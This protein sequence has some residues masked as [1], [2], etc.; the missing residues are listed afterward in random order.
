MTI[1]GQ[2]RFRDYLSTL[3]ELPVEGAAA[4][5]GLDPDV[6]RI[7]EGVAFVTAQTERRLDDRIDVLSE[8]LLDVFHPDALLP[9]PAL[10]VLELESAAHGRVPAGIEATSVPLGGIPCRFQTIYDAIVGPTRIEAVRAQSQGVSIALEGISPDFLCHQPLRLFLDGEPSAAAALYAWIMRRA[11][12]VELADAQ[13]GSLGEA[14]EVSLHR[15]GF[16]PSEHAFVGVRCPDRISLLREYLAFPEKFLF[17]DVS[18]LGAALQRVGYLGD[19]LRL[20]FRG[21]LQPSLRTATFRL[22]AVPAVNVLRHWAEPYQR[23]SFEASVPLRPYGREGA[24]EVYRVER[25]L[26]RGSRGDVHYSLPSRTMVGSGSRMAQAFREDGRWRLL[27]VDPPGD[28]GSGTVSVELSCTNGRLASRLAVGDVS[29]NQ[30]DLRGHNIQPATTF[31]P[32][33]SGRDLRDILV[34]YLA[35]PHLRTGETAHVR[36][37][38]EV[39]DYSER[40]GASVAG[41]VRSSRRESVVTLLEGVPVRGVVTQVE[42]DE[43]DFP[44]DGEIFLFG[45]VLEEVIAS[46]TPIGF[47]SEL[48][49]V[50]LRH[51]QVMRWP[52]RF[53]IGER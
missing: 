32:A 38:L 50:G 28:D 43:A 11:A 17:I 13:G 25:I 19:R 41:A 10:T 16:S 4:V 12:P 46:Q 18:G 42:V 36:A 9:C 27:L 40:A 34:R 48:S 2:D 6:D 14:R 51:R 26:R 35:L 7:L 20:V 1:P 31:L 30:R 3:A 52:R 39:A 33:P 29:V 22:G 53:G 44:G 15:V 49:L 21:E 23:R 45:C 37:I 5:S 47:F 8:L 24:F